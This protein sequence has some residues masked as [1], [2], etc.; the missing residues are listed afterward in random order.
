VIIEW[1]SDRGKLDICSIEGWKKL[2][3][4]LFKNFQV[5]SFHHIYRDFNKEADKLSKEALLAPEGKITYYQWEPGGA[6]QTK[7]LDIY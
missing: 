4:D 2:T 6:G 3:K 5:L 1:L 7:N